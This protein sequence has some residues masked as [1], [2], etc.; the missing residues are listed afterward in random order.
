MCPVKQAI[1]G[2]FAGDRLHFNGIKVKTIPDIFSKY[3]H[4]PEIYPF[5][6]INLFIKNN[7]RYGDLNC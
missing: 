3:A 2:G 7:G 4:T 6:G 5:S 1:P